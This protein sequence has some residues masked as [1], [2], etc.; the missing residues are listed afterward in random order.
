MKVQTVGSISEF[1][2]VGQVQREPEPFS[3]KA[4]RHFK[5]YGFVYKV[6]GIT[7]ILLASG[8]TAFANGL[9]IEAGA[10]K[11]YTKLLVIGKWIIIFK[12]GFDIIKNLTNGDMDSAKKGFMSYLLIYLLL[13]GLPWVMDEIEVLFQDLKVNA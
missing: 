13:F 2:Q 8:G 12:G 6:A 11:L 4:E 1:L 5:K 7:I 3:A 9:G 10:E